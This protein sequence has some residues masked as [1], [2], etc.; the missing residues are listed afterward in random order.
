MLIIHTGSATVTADCQCVIGGG[1]P[2][3]EGAVLGP[4]SGSIKVL[5]IDTE[6]VRLAAS[7]GVE[8]VQTLT[9]TTCIVL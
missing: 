1:W 5:D 6:L 3:T 7:D 2:H 8:Q 4:G 9:P